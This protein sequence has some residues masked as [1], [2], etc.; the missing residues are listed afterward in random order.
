[1]KRPV[2]APETGFE[3]LMS[4]AVTVT[5]R[6]PLVPR[7]KAQSFGTIAAR[8]TCSV[9]LTCVFFESETFVEPCRLFTVIVLLF[10]ACGVMLL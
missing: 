10:A 9:L 5:P 8:P 1:M 4:V 2:Q 6:S 7:T 3:R